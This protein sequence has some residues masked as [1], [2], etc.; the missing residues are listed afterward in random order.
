MIIDA[1]MQHPNPAWIGDPIFE[2]LR[3][4]R[5][6]KWSETAPP[7]GDSLAEMD[8]AGVSMGM[9]CGWH[10]PG[11][12]MIS[13]D[14]VAQHCQAHPDRFV[15]IASVDLF[16]PM[17]DPTEERPSF[18]SAIEARLVEDHFAGR[19]AFPEYE[20]KL[21]ERG[22]ERYPAFR[23]PA[24]VFQ[25]I[26]RV[27]KGGLIVARCEFSVER[28]MGEDAVFAFIRFDWSNGHQFSPLDR[29]LLGSLLNALTADPSY[30]SVAAV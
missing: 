19:I 11:G 18:S 3:R 23:Q 6:G 28:G 1:W 15:G 14:E 26:D 25:D 9:L 24:P 20:G 22:S 8:R 27:Y 13:N 10:G 17:D 7:I 4:W 16:R 12:P 5:P 30:T 21:L 29:Q 2:S